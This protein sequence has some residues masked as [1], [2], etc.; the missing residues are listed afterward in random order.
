MASPKTYTQN[1][2]KVT[3]HDPENVTTEDCIALARLGKDAWNQWRREYPTRGDGALRLN[4]ANFRNCIFDAGMRN[5]F[6]GFEFGDAA[7]FEGAIF[8]ESVFFSKA[9]FGAG[10]SF[11]GAKFQKFANFSGAKF[12]EK[13][14]FAATQFF[15]IADF[16]NADLGAD[17]NFARARF[18]HADFS[19]SRLGYFARFDEASLGSLADFNGTLCPSISFVDSLFDSMAN[20]SGAMFGGA[21]F[22]GAQIGGSARFDGQIW[23]SLRGRFRDTSSFEKHRSKA[24][25]LGLS[26]S[27][28]GG[29]T[30]RGVRFGSGISFMNRTFTGLLDFGFRRA[31]CSPRNPTDGDIAKVPKV[32]KVG[33]AIFDSEGGLVWEKALGPSRD[34]ST[35]FTSFPMFYG[36][37][38]TSNTNF[39]KAVFPKATGS[40]KAANAYRTLKYA[41][42][43]QQALREEQRFFRLEMAEEAL[44]EDVH[45][46]WLY[47]SYG[48]VSDFGFSLWR[49]LILFVLTLCLSLIA[50]GY[51]AGMNVCFF[52][53]GDC[54]IS[55][56]WLQFGIVQSLPLPGC[57]KLG[58]SLRSSL[59]SESNG[60]VVTIVIVFQKLASILSLFLLGLAIRN[61]FRMK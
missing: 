28:F 11:S 51:L 9:D 4:F 42:G 48:L 38:L 5:W 45:R 25:L 19:I 6:E 24:N 59:F 14:C 1:N 27:E 50:Y 60:L 47:K 57:D 58:E 41:F 61:L 13:V 26:P 55:G 15:S 16:S 3:I 21:D 43:Q 53:F 52:G 33:S 2:Q 34:E 23:D 31:N 49:P 39:S 12:G 32:D 10:V 8:E 22:D 29:I 54:T 20:F 46:R 44:V 30:F 17:A 40:E 18:H 37:K 7:N 56:D 35:H 36:S